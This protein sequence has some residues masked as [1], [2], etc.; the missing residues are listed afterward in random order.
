MDDIR[1]IIKYSN[2][3]WPVV[4]ERQFDIVEKE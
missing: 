3:H 1:E 4:A 2:F